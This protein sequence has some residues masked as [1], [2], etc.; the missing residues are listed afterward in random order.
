MSIG[1][2]MQR[3]KGNIT[4]ALAAIADKGVTVP[5]G[6]NS[7]ALAGLI[8]SIE[9]GGS[10]ESRCVYGSFIPED[11]SSVIT[12]DNA[13]PY[14]TK[15]AMFG[16]SE[17]GFSTLDSTHTLTRVASV[18]AVNQ[19]LDVG[20]SNEYMYY[21]TYCNNGSYLRK[22]IGESYTSFMGKYRV[23]NTLYN[24]MEGLINGETRQ[25]R[26]MHSSSGGFLLSGKTYI[27]FVIFGDDAT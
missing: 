22:Y 13:F 1:E 3:I 7:D 23:G 6:S 8:A 24:V 21:I 12:I 15:P 2:D 17:I 4:A 10:V 27:W 14:S 19:S 20:S 11:D 26:F 5:D 9:A 25:L 18:I 16:V